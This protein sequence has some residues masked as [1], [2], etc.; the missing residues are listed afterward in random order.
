MLNYASFTYYNQITLMVPAQLCRHQN[1]IFREGDS[2]ILPFKRLWG[3]DVTSV[4]K[5]WQFG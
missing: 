1:P 2:S 5:H 3:T 4:V